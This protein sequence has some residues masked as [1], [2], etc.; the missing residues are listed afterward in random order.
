MPPRHGKTEIATVKFPAWYLGRNT[1]KE[2]ICCSYSADLAEEFGRKA[3]AC[4]ADELHGAI[5]PDCS[6]QTGSKS[7]TNWKVS[8]RGG[9]TATGVGGAITGKGANIFIID[10]P[11]KN[12]EEAESETY[13]KRVWDWYTSTAFTRLEKDGA[14]VLVQTRWHD[15]DLAGRLL[16]LEGEKGQIYNKSQGKWIKGRSNN[17]NARFGKWDVVRFPAVAVEDEI[18]R[19]Q[20]EALWP[21]KYDTEAL[22]DIKKA[23]GMRDWGA[24]Y[25]QDPVTEEGADFKTEWFKYWKELPKGVRYITTVDLAISQKE[26]ADDSVVMTV[27][28]DAHDN[29]Y[30]VD[31][32]NW[33]ANPSE[34]IDE[35]YNHY[36]KY[37]GYI[38]VES[39]GYQQSLFHYLRLAGQKRGQYLP[40]EEIRTRADKESKIRGLIPF[41]ANGKVF[42]DK[43]NCQDLEDQLKRFPSGKHDD[44][45][46]ALAMTLGLLRRP[47]IYADMKTDVT[48]SIGIKYTKDGRPYI[49]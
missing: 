27:A 45:I 10:D 28:F 6:L 12:R 17:P 24:L 9:F 16:A 46:D 39:V 2:I 18:Y 25:Q 34:V 43:N 13:R 36:N 42:H 31:Y 4:V 38:G 40:V 37:H 32:K 7:A 29:L 22:E 19:K 49:T 47:P 33:K 14:I 48:S 30:V 8:S 26:S 41:Y 44:V 11:I 1:D 3:R 15:D 20:G 35:I 21:D 23:V 5:F